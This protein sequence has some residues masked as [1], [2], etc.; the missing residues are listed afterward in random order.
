MATTVK[1][2]VIGRDTAIDYPG[3]V[4]EFDPDTALDA[5]S[6]ATSLFRLYDNDKQSIVLAPETRLRTAMAA[7]ETAAQIPI[8]LPRFHEDGD[9]VELDL[10][11]GTLHVTTVASYDATDD[12]FD[13]ITLTAGIPAGRSMAEGAKIRLTTK[14]IGGKVFAINSKRYQSDIPL[15]IGDTIEME[16][17]TVATFDSKVVDEMQRL[18]ATEVVDDLPVDAAIDQPLYDLLLLT[19]GSSTAISPGRMVRRKYGAD[20]TMGEYGTVVAGGEDWGWKGVISDTLDAKLGV[21][22]LVE[23]RFTGSGGGLNDKVSFVLPV[24]GG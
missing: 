11:D 3:P 4:D 10:D 23:I 24:V 17:D 9:T 7:A 12:S 21:N 13:E 15:E 14:A 8:M 6:G 20:N 19:V 1:N 18:S 16:T 22:L 2:H 5:A